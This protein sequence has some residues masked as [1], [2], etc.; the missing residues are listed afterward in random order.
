MMTY[1]SYKDSGIEWIGEI[2]SDFNVISIKFLVTT[3]PLYQPRLKNSFT[4]A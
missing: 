3:Y 1:D 4:I 2:P